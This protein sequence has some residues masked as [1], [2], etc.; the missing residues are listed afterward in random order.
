MA[1][2]FNRVTLSRALRFFNAEEILLLQ[3]FLNSGYQRGIALAFSLY[4]PGRKMVAC[5]AAR[6]EGPFMFIETVWHEPGLPVENVFTEVLS[7]M[8]REA[9]TRGC[10]F[11]LAKS[12]GTEKKFQYINNGYVEV[13]ENA[14]SNSQNF[15]DILLKK[16]N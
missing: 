4:A 13:Q 15:K 16:L 12:W 2:K 3:R 6:T 7:A 5:A 11:S 8:E 9:T 1:T 14:E 10:K